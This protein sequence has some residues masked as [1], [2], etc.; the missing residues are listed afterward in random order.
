MA[1]FDKF[2]PLLKHY[3][4]VNAAGHNPFKVNIEQVLSPTV[5]FR[6][7]FCA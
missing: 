5:L 3:A 7:R 2:A 4:D 6:Y 1:L